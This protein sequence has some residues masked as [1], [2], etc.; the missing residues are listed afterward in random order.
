MGGPYVPTEFTEDVLET[1]NKERL[2]TEGRYPYVKYY[3]QPTSFIDGNQL[4]SSCPCHPTHFLQP[5][6][7]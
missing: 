6:P 5:L 2:S 7:M 4:V 1:E 3:G